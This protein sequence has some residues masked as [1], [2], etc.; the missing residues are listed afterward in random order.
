MNLVLH[1]DINKTI[2]VSDAST[3]R[4]LEASLHSLLSEVC[5]GEYSS[6]IERED[7]SPS[8]WI[9][10]LDH[11]SCSPPTDT[12]VS[13]GTYLEDHTNVPK[14]ERRLLKTSFAKPG[15]IGHMF[16]P[17]VDHLMKK[18]TISSQC[19]MA[20]NLQQE[21][22]EHFFILPSFFNLLDYLFSE[23]ILSIVN[24]RIVF[25]SFGID[26]PSVIKE[27]NDF[28]NGT[29]PH[30]K[31]S[32]LAET[33]KYSIILADDTA[34]LIRVGSSAKDVQLAYINAH[35]VV[36]TLSTASTIQ[37]YIV[38]DWLM[39]EE[40][41]NSLKKFAVLRDDYRWWEKNNE[42]DDSGKIILI[43]QRSLNGIEWRQNNTEASKSNVLYQLFFD[44]NIER[45]RA[46]IVDARDIITFE[47]IPFV[48]TKDK[49]LFRV[50]PY[51]AIC[52]DDYFVNIIKRV[53]KNESINC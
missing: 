52:E 48:E 36:T 8:D 43:D 51:L 12:A 39:M 16:G 4:G 10:I 14:K 53:L 32:N 27:I 47:P 11:P 5:W 33:S 37:N 34:A 26:T 22:I 1:F 13:F 30:F 20:C 29:H 44:D 28:L 18:M 17:F 25:R 15:E 9:P 41:R 31:P 7:R 19:G 42:S 3:N 45:D 21:A 23:E 38:H 46:H 49:F 50:E 6:S 24:W 2:V 35:N 40:G